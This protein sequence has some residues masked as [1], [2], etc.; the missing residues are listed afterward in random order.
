MSWWKRIFRRR[1][2]YDDLS[3]EVR[4]HIEEKTEQLMRLENISRIEAREAALRAFGN[5]TV[6]EQRSR[7]TWQWPGIESL[8]AD[9]KLALRRLRKSPGFAIVVILTLAIGIG[10][11]TAVFSVV[12]G[13]L[14]KPLQ[15]PEA[16]RLVTLNLKAPGAPGLADFRDGLRLSASMY[17]TFAAH[18]RAFQSV[19]VWAP[20]TAN[21]TGL[22]QPEQVNAAMVSDGVLQTFAVPPAAGRWLDATDQ[23]PRGAKRVMLGYGYWQRR[24]GGDRSVIGRTIELDSQPREIVGVMPRGFRVLN[25]DFDLLVPLAFEQ[26]K[27]ILAGFEYRGVARLRP[28]IS[29]DKADA[30]VARLLDVWM[31]SWRNCPKCDSYFYLTWQIGPA[32][33]PMKDEVLGGVSSALWVVMSTIGLVMLIACTNIANLLLV[34]ADSRQQELAVRAALGAGRSRI[35]RELLVESLLLGILGG[36]GGVIIAT[37]GLRLLLAIGPA[38]LPRLSEVRF[39]GW[40][41][42]FTLALALFSG[43]FFG[44][45]PALKY[46]RMHALVALRAGGRTASA[47]RERQ[48]GRSALVIAQV[49]MALVLLISAMLMIRTFAALRNVDPGFSDPAHLQTLRIAIPASLVSDPVTVT[50][51]QNSIVDKL[52]AIPGSC[53]SD[54][55][56]PCLCSRSSLTGTIFFFRAGPTKTTKRRCACITTFR[57]ATFTLQARRSSPAGISHGRTPTAKER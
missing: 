18:N 56:A 4:E 37:A 33:R 55:P 8:L 44:S 29:I 47:S 20:A 22:A 49:A 3:E 26:Q 45:I 5:P 34:R 54:S 6:I 28:G 57:R 35:V 27:Q 1:H 36:G 51:I 16:E 32:L 7:E 21:V 9:V 41:L 10:A 42:A 2:L 24:F 25:C 12:D 15:Y 23:D 53:L 50:H 14:I 39:D 13:V 43:L 17:L 40:S 48:H 19:G 31:A 52:A 30:D 38:N 11:N 46:A